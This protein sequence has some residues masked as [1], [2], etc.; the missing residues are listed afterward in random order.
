MMKCHVTT[1]TATQVM[2]SRPQKST[3]DSM[4]EVPMS[5]SCH[6]GG[7]GSQG[8]NAVI[9]RG[10][11][12][13]SAFPSCHFDGYHDILERLQTYDTTLDQHLAIQSGIMR[14]STQLFKLARRPLSYRGPLALAS[15]SLSVTSV[16]HDA[17]GQG[18]EVIQPMLGVAAA[19]K[20]QSDSSF[21]PKVQIFDEF[22]LKNGVAVVSQ[23]KRSLSHLS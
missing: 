6:L 11:P 15:R 13:A 20:A 21:L 8:H 2:I 17:Q 1:T 3:L 12:N 5:P 18:T 19:M 4:T 23:L 10:R 22:A 16:L 14:L 7:R 9:Q